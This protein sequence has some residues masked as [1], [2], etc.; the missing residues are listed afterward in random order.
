M[1]PSI[2]FWRQ[3]WLAL[4]VGALALWLM[5]AR[6]GLPAAAMDEGMLLVYPE[7]ILNGKLPYR[8]FDTAYGPGNPYV[9]AGVF[10]VSG[11]GI[12]TER[13]VGLVYRLAILAAIGALAWC[14]GA[15]AAGTAVLMAG[16]LLI[17]TNLAA[18]AW[19]GGMGCALW[20]VCL[21]A[22]QGRVGGKFGAGLLAGLALLFRADLGLAVGLPALALWRGMSARERKAFV[23]GAASGLAPLG[24]LA[25]AVGPRQL[26]ENLFH[27]P[28]L[29]SG[30]SLPLEAGWMLS[31]LCLHFVACA[32]ALGFGWAAWRADR[33]DPRARLLLAAGFCA[34][35]CSH[36]AL[37]RFDAIH[38]FFTCFTSLALLP[39]ALLTALD[40]RAWPARGRALLVTAATCGMVAVA[41]P[42]MGGFLQQAIRYATGAAPATAPVV[43]SHGRV[44]PVLP[45]RDVEQLA[46]CLAAVQQQAVAGERLF[47]GPRDLRHPQY[48][49]TFLY[50]LLPQLEPATYFLEMNP[51][52][53]DRPGSRLAADVASADWLILNHA[54]DAHVGSATVGEPTTAGDVVRAQFTR[55]QAAGSFEVYRKTARLALAQP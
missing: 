18:Y 50:H 38:V 46:P 5:S 47:V 48:A 54:R 51:G 6:W 23:S 20:S 40:L 17:P 19:M 4:I 34:L 52:S 37:Q 13:A 14:W 41:C 1:N 43:A 44:F 24:L 32:L 28:V 29:H 49:D 7:R 21:A 12:A 25:A 8:D 36:Q 22:G 15:L 11:P 33:Q 2:A 30:R 42:S 55:V 10:A 26:Y 35:G 31:L 27:F 16:V 9:L 53:V 45:G 3:G 39:L